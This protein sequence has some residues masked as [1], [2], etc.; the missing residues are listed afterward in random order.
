MNHSYRTN[1][2]VLAKASIVFRLIRKIPILMYVFRWL[3]TEILFFRKVCGGSWY[4]EYF[5]KFK[6]A[7]IAHYKHYPQTTFPSHRYFEREKITPVIHKTDKYFV[8]EEFY[9]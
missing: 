2:L 3:G 4:L 5:Y 9:S 8:V 6:G 7:V 1:E